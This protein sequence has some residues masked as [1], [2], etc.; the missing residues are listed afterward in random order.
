[1]TRDPAPAICKEF[2]FWTA[3]LRFSPERVEF[4]WAKSFSRGAKHPRSKVASVVLN[5]LGKN[6]YVTRALLE[7]V[8]IYRFP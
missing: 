2:A 5:G 6:R 8:N 7:D 3:R 1:M 4:E